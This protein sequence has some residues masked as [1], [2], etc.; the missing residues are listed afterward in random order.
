MSRHLIPEL[1]VPQEVPLVVHNGVRRVLV[2]RAVILAEGIA[3]YFDGE[4]DDNYVK[5]LVA[6]IR[7]GA[8][9]GLSIVPTQPCSSEKNEERE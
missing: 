4:L 9:N 6:A 3:A 2:G 1:G 7:K 5:S 8:I